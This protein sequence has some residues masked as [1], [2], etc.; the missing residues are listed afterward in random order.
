MTEDEAKAILSARVSRETFTRLELYAGLLIKW[1]KTIN[2]VSPATLPQLWAR[3]MLDSAQV[4]DHAPQDA[5][6]WLDL[7][8]GGGFPGLVCAAIAA[9]SHPGLKI[10][11]VEA[12]LRKA[13]FLRETARQM[14]LSVGVFSRRIE[15]LP[16]QSADVISARALAPLVTLCG[17]AHRHLSDT[18]VAL[19]QKGARH[20]EELETARQGWQMDVTVIPSVTDAEAVLFR[21]EDLTDV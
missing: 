2:L 11:L 1:Q 20:A 21:I 13:A 10:D 3:H 16:P 17:Y 15:D 14:G 4:I 18:G 12:D 19:F 5:K 9:E 8:S 7:G 6:T